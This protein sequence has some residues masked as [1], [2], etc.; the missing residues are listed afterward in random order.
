MARELME[1]IAHPVQLRK[2]MRQHGFT[3][4]S[5]AKSAGCGVGTI[6]RLVGGAAAVTSRHIAEAIEKELRVEPGK[7]FAMPEVIH[8]PQ[9]TEDHDT[10]AEGVSDA[11]A[12]EAAA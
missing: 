4:R 11:S 10:R 1:L 3:N 12:P 8:E 9:K 6:G 7:L 2:R 5:L